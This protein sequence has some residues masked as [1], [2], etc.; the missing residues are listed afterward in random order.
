MDA[1][2][3]AL[4]QVLKDHN[5]KT[6]VMIAV[7]Y[8]YKYVHAEARRKSGLVMLPAN[9][10]FEDSSEDETFARLVLRPKL[11]TSVRSKLLKAVEDIKFTRIDLD[12]KDHCD[13]TGDCLLF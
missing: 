3:A 13:G 12:V 1:D 5:N 8:F 10:T 4:F 9:P 7:K 2:A 11:P 6:V